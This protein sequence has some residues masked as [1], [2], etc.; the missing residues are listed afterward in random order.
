MRFLPSRALRGDLRPP[1]DKS[2]SHRAALF[3]AMT[4]REVT[5]RNFLASADTQAT[6]DAVAELGA[7]VRSTPGG[8]LAICGRGLQGAR[9]L[10][11]P[12]DV[13]NSGTLLRLAPGWLAGQRDGSWTLDGDSSIRRRPVDRVA[14]PLERMGAHVS[15]REGRWP[16]LTVSGSPL[17]GCEHRL[18]LASAQ[19][20]SC[21]LLAALQAESRTT[22][23]QPHPSRD[24]T[25]RLLLRAGAAI[26]GTATRIEVGPSDR[27]E[28]DTIDVPG[29]PSSAAF[30]ACAC[31]VIPNSRIRL[32]GVGLNWTRSGFY[33]IAKRMG[34]GV[35]GE[36]EPP[37]TRSDQEPVGD[38]ELEW[39]Q[40]EATTVAGDEVPLAI[41]ELPL[42]ALLGVFA[43]GT[44]VVSGAEELR[45]KESDRIT[46]LTRELARLGAQIE[47]TEDGFVVEGTGGLQGGVFDAAGDH[48]LAMLGAICGLAAR[49]G[50]EVRGIEHASVSYPTFVDDLAGLF[51]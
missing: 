49:Q 2:V 24:H 23:C 51:G 44:T 9:R 42:V 31:F 47:A 37:G 8:E 33:R 22:I 32:R 1:A 46:Q 50:V 19:V 4:E 34:A 40:L 10:A 6:L 48:R 14:A 39:A 27:L 3:A 15:A 11:R 12:I 21:L 25:E 43:E 5:V 35:H 17:H 38:I 29:D 13:R 7:T 30:A 45:V 28:L 18:E 36:L 20:K 41:D 26:E 16:P